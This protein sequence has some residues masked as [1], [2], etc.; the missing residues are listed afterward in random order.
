MTYAVLDGVLNGVTTQVFRQYW[1]AQHKE[2][3]IFLVRVSIAKWTK[4]SA[5]RYTAFDGRLYLERRPDISPCW[6]ARSSIQNHLIQKTTRTSD[7]SDAKDVAEKW[8]LN[9]RQHVEQ[10]I[11]VAGRTFATAAAAFLTHH[12][13]TL[14]PIGESNERKIRSYRDVWNVLRD[15]IDDKLLTELDIVVLEALCLWRKSTRNVSDKTLRRD[16]GLVRLVLKFAQRQRWIDHLPLFPQLTSKPVSPD[17]FSP[18]E[19]THLLATSRQRILD[20]A[21]T[22]NASSHIERERKELHAFILAMGHGCIRVDECL[23]LRWNDLTPEPKNEALP[24][25]KKTVLLRIR[26]GK[27]GKR[28]GIGTFG[29]L[30]PMDM[31]RE[32]HPDALDEDKIFSTPHPQTFRKL[33]EAANLRVDTQGR[34][35]N[36]KT[37]RHTSLRFRFL[38]QPEIRPHELAV[39]GGTSSKMLEDYY[40]RHLTAELVQDRLTKQALECL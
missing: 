28:T 37:I 10:G 26:R 4:Q 35:R 11:P 27:T 36:A 24:F 30:R 7:L 38:Y 2:F 29:T 15:F 21:K 34:F 6:H 8:F 19:W 16:I 40:L 1:D 25:R 33:L 5:N 39:I 14:L 18:K 12:E 3:I 23:N 22:G 20:A 31:L 32:L 9:L 13:H 17:W